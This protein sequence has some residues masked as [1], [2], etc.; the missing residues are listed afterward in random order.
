[1]Q[2]MLK[3]LLIL[4]MIIGSTFSMAAREVKTKDFSGWMEDYD[5]LTY[6][7]ER[8]AFLFFNE[9][10]RGTYSKVIL[11]EVSVYS[12]IGEADPEIAQE[13]TTYLS[14]GISALLEKKGIAA[15]EAGGGVLRLKWAITGA[16]KSKED[17]KEVMWTPT[18]S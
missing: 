17:L 14:Q 5:S 10:R 13:A 1:M 2:S 16:E 6:S 15:S 11:D 9:A 7:E 4:F 12:K 18:K 8:N 3:V